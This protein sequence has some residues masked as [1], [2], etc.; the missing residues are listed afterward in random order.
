M[1]YTKISRRSFLKSAASCTVSLPFIQGCC[2][3]PTTSSPP[4]IL[5][6]LIDDQRN[7]TL[8]C[9]GHPLLQTPN[10]DS[11][12]A[13]GCRFENAFVTTSICAASRASI[14]SICLAQSIKQG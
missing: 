6:F 8:G 11:I 3:N 7:D 5:F 4:N 13:K 9:A 2:D 14:V 1:S 12:A 10:I